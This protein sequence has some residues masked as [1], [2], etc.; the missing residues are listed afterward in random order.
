MSDGKELKKISVVEAFAKSD[1][2]RLLSTVVWYSYAENGDYLH[3]NSIE[4][5]EGEDAERLPFA[6]EGQVLLSF[7]E[8]GT[9]AV[10]D[11]EKEEIVWALRD[12]KSTRLNSSH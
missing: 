4:V 2:L 10:L 3:T 12:R 7:R 8:I 1:Y 9:I 11:I 6:S 5:I